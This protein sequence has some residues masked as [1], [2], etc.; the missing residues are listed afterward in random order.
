[1]QAVARCES[2]V[3]NDWLAAGQRVYGAAEKGRL[4]GGRRTREGHCGPC[5]AVTVGLT[6]SRVGEPARDFTDQSARG[7][8]VDAH[9]TGDRRL[10][11]LIRQGIDATIATPRSG[12]VVIYLTDPDARGANL[13]SSGSL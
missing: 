12:F 6:S 1:M 7:R 10:R 2:A 11:A 3:P 8:E 9:R 13:S 4:A 5:D